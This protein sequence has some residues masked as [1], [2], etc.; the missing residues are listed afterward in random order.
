MTMSIFSRIYR[1]F[2][3]KEETVWEAPDDT[4]QTQ[5]VHRK[6]N[7]KIKS[8]LTILYFTEEQAN[9]IRDIQEE[10]YNGYKDDL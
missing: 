9:R 8:T 1:W 5:K 7:G 10:L 3:P 4:T 2:V 6:R